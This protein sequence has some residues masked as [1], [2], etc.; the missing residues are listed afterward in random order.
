MDPVEAYGG[1]HG[2]A[3]IE[4][5]HHSVHIVDMVEEHRTKL[6]DLQCLCANCHRVVHRLLK[7]EIDEPTTIRTN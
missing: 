5:H 1:E 2:E 4:V 6:E 3:C 7:L